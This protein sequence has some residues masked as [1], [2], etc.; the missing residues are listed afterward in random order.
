MK[1][2]TLREKETTDLFG[3]F[4][5]NEIYQSNTPRLLNEYVTMEDLKEYHKNNRIILQQLEDYDLITVEVVE[6]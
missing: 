2:K 1:Y 4:H 5:S 3:V 6:V